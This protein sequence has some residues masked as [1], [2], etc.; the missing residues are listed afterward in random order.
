MKNQE[1]TYSLVINF[2]EL[3]S[4]FYCIKNGKHDYIP[5]NLVNER[6]HHLLFKY[7]SFL[8]GGPTTIA[9]SY[10]CTCQCVSLSTVLNHILQKKIKA[11][12]L[13]YYLFL[14][15]PRNDQGWLQSMGAYI[16]TFLRVQISP[17]PRFLERRKILY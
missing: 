6:S 1:I 9:S 16:S 13:D 5:N 17:C 10:S 14:S 2:I 11:S 4:K 7:F 8:Q 3:E 12:L 15:P